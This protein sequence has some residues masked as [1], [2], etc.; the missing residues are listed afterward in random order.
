MARGTRR[1][2]FQGVFLDTGLEHGTQ[3]AEVH[4]EQ[5]AIFVVDDFQL[6]E[7]R[8]SEDHTDSERRKAKQVT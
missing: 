8:L 7:S 4:S 6:N 3:S 1:D 5:G 2:G